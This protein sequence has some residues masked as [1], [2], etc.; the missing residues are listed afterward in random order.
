[1]T[2]AIKTILLIASG[3]ILGGMALLGGN[4]VIK[5][6]KAQHKKAIEVEKAKKNLERQLLLD[7]YKDIAITAVESVD[8]TYSEEGADIQKAAELCEDEFKEPEKF[9]IRKECK[10]VTEYAINYHHVKSSLK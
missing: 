3:V 6:A 1:M 8:K 5:H 7:K 10:E 9:N 4:E 2:N